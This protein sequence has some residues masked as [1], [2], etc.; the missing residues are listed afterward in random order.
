[1]LLHHTFSQVNNFKI[2]IILLLVIFD[3]HQQFY[4]RV[5]TL[6]YY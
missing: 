1:M 2:L 3:I 4:L 5:S 6:K